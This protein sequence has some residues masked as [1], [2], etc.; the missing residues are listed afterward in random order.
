M[1]PT[2]AMLP[3]TNKRLGWTQ[4]PIKLILGMGI[5]EAAEVVI[6]RK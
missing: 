4:D 2:V 5:H 3:R 6:R 1:T